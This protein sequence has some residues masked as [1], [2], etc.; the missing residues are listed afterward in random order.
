[1]DPELQKRIDEAKAEGY[2][3]EEIAKALG[4]EP[5]APQATLPNSPT[6]PILSAEEKAAFQ[7]ADKQTAER[8]TGE[9]YNTAAAGAAAVTV[10][11]LGTYGAYK[12]LQSLG[13]KIMQPVAPGPMSAPTAPIAPQAAAARPMPTPGTSNVYQLRPVAPEPSMTNQVRQAAASRIMPAMGQA[14]QMAGQVLS[15]AAPLMRGANI[16]GAAMY[17]GG[18]NTNEEEELRKRR[19]MQ[20]TITR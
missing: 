18:L 13:Q 5:P 4:M 10:G 7:Q 11:G 6:V 8:N 19:M 12:G 17:S 9:N 16:A 2:N 14:G 3:D 1:M 15:K 20:P